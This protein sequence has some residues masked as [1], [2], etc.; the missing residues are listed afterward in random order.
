MEAGRDQSLDRRYCFLGVGPTARQCYAGIL[1]GAEHHQTHNRSGGYRLVVMAH[2]YFG[3]ELLR[4][5]DQL[6]CGPCVKSPAVDNSCDALGCRT[7]R[8]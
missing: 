4:Y 8:H 3:L 7:N 6:G 2:Q 5:I 1:T